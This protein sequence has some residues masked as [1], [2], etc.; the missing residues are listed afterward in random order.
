LIGSL[1]HAAHEI[2]LREL[3]KSSSSPYFSQIYRYNPLGNLIEIVG[4][5]KCSYEGLAPLTKEKEGMYAY[6]SLDSRKR[7][8]EHWLLNARM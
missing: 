5:G 2:N 1:G 7:W 6:D 4:R 8:Q 3:K